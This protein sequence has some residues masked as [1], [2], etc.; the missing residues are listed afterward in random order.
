MR[1]I[2]RINKQMGKGNISRLNDKVKIGIPSQ[3]V[4]SDL[5]FSIR[6]PVF[7]NLPSISP[8]GH[9]IEVV[10]VDK[11][12]GRNVKKFSAPLTLQI[13][14][15]EATLG[16]WAED[17]LLIYYY[18]AEKQD[19]F[20]YET[21]V[22]TKSNTLTAQTDHLTVFDYKASTWQAHD[23][24]TVD[25]FQVSDFT[26]A[27]TIDINLWT[28]PGVAGL[29]PQVVLNYNSQVIDDSYAFSQASW[30]G[31]GWSLETGSI[32][33]NMHG[34]NTDTS[35][36]TYSLSLGGV[37]SMLLPT[38]DPA[39][40][41]VTYHTADETFLKIEFYRTASPNPYWKVYDQ[42]GK[43][44]LFDGP[45]KTDLGNGCVTS[46]STIWKWSLGTVTDINNNVLLYT[47][48]NEQK[49]PGTCNNIV[50]VYP[51]YI[52]Y[53]SSAATSKYRIQFF[54]ESRNDWM[55]STVPMA[56]WGATGMGKPGPIQSAAS[57]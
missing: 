7:N 30:V 38:T 25:S 54:R 47:Y 3:D 56:A 48:L 20:P 22:D 10:A 43:V 52:Y 9:P 19:W 46:P 45:S 16:K 42:A 44:Y 26:G 49:T 14:Y 53:G 13:T 24:P 15:D 50:A 37:S 40:S 31:M 8:S 36:D 4:A 51:E 6:T 41:V 12:L 17:D 32:T 39:G 33:R 21:I 2:A 23:L 35:D 34:T 18:D 11:A 27:A 55:T 57:R 28:P 5:T 29:Q 1:T